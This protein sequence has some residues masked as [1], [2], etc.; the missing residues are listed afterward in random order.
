MEYTLYLLPG[1]D[2]NWTFLQYFILLEIIFSKNLVSDI[3]TLENNSL[4]MIEPV[5]SS[6]DSTNIFRLEYMAKLKSFGTL[7]PPSLMK[8][9]HRCFQ[10]LDQTCHNF[11][12][13]GTKFIFP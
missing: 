8:S 6:F 3:F 10:I 4:K 2:K 1:I 11:R 5:S 12:I 9:C 7:I 13:S